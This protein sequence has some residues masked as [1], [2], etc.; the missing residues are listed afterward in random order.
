MLELPTN[1]RLRR[2]AQRKTRRTKGVRPMDQVYILLTFELFHY[3]E[4]LVV[5]VRLVQKLVFDLIQV[6]QGIVNIERSICAITRL[7]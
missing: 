3:I 5:N 1:Q 4:K 7:R 2:M 6:S